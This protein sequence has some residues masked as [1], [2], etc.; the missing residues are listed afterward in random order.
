MVQR[1]RIGF[2]GLGVVGASLLEMIRTNKEMLAKSC[3]LHIEVGKVYVRDLHK[4]RSVDV[5]QI[6]LTQNPFEVV[7]DPSIHII[8]ECMGGTGTEVSREL[9][10]KALENN[11]SVVMSSKKCLAMYGLEIIKKSIEH[12]QFLR[13]D[14]SVGGCIPISSILRNSYKGERNNRILGI[15][16]ATSNYIYTLMNEENCSFEEALRNA[17]EKG[18]TENDPKED[19][20]GIDSMNKLI[21][22]VGFSM[23][24]WID[25]KELKPVPIYAIEKE[26]IE[27]ASK[28]DKVIKQISIAEFKNNQ[29]YYYVGPCLIKDKSII[30]NVSHNFNIIMLNGEW[31][32]TKA[33]YGQGAGAKPTASAMFDD[34][35]NIVSEIQSNV[36]DIFEDKECCNGCEAILQEAIQLANI[37]K[38]NH[39]KEWKGDFYV[40]LQG[41]YSKENV[42]EF[43]GKQGLEMDDI[44]SIQYGSELYT[45]VTLKNTEQKEITNIINKEV[46]E[47]VTYV[48][49]PILS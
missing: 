42:K 25:Y 33:F 35:I 17:R 47:K 28:K 15:F 46:G 39:V 10:T 26:D 27:Y 44:D 21:I 32:G 41:Y 38:F 36:G 5:T 1:F 13:Y 30:S 48:S 19:I 8:I 20:D 43:F 12:K 2:L 29:L 7:E 37:E 45:I 49:I 16:N 24:K 22:M 23:S 11:K 6:E 40:R 31:S 18:F 4:K 34:M 9:I 3:G 14:A